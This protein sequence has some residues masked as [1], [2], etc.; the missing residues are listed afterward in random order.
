MNLHLQVILEYLIPFLK[1]YFH[2]FYQFGLAKVFENLS[3]DGGCHWIITI[4]YLVYASIIS[5][6]FDFIC[7]YPDAPVCNAL[8]SLSSSSKRLKLKYLLKDI[9]L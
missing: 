8:K 4:I 5:I 3:C 2:H 1:G 6:I 9:N 7:K